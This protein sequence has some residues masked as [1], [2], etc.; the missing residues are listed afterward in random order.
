MHITDGKRQSQYLEENFGA[1]NI[2]LTEEELQ[3]EREVSENADLVNGDRYPPS[4]KAVHFADA[5]P[6]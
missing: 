3:E 2:K 5:P 1:L 4:F 6:L